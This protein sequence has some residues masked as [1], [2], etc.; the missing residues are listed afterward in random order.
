VWVHGGGFYEGTRADMAAYAEEFARRGFLTVTIDY[1]LHTTG[2]L[3]RGGWGR[4]LADAQHD[5]QAAVRWLRHRASALGVDERR[6]YLGGFSAGA[7]AALRASERAEDPG[8]SGSP[9][10][11]SRVAGAI[12]VAGGGDVGSIDAGDPPVLL[13]HGTRDVLV[14][15]RSSVRTCAAY[16]RAEANCS[17]VT[18]P[19]AGHELGVLSLERR[20]FPAVGRWLAR[21]G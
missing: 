4:A 2:F 15:Y 20:V 6:I 9:G 19:G 13:L 17:L 14:P 1:R 21:R 16:R 11:S 12:G 10:V 5:A 18:F 8:R 3:R 7:F